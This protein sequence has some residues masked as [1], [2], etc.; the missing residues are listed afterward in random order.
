M[1]RSALKLESAK[2]YLDEK[3]N[4]LQSKSEAL[5]TDQAALEEARR[6]FTEK[7][8]DLEKK[9]YELTEKEYELEARRQTLE[10]QN[11]RRIRPLRIFSVSATRRLPDMQ[12][13]FV[14]ANNCKTNRPRS[15]S[16]R[17]ILLRDR[18]STISNSWN[19]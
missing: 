10:M 6:Q 3:E 9:N 11:R 1:K 19:L 7:Q 14:S 18:Q 2:T 13:Y 5:E 16:S 8:A 4:E 12:S 15:A 17:R